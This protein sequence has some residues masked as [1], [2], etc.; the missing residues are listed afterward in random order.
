MLL[1]QGLNLGFGYRCFFFFPPFFCNLSNN[2]MTRG[3]WFQTLDFHSRCSIPQYKLDKSVQ[4]RERVRSSNKILARTI[5][6]QAYIWHNGTICFSIL[7]KAQ[8]TI[9]LLTDHIKK[10][11]SFLIEQYTPSAIM[12]P[13]VRVPLQNQLLI[14]DTFQK[15]GFPLKQQ[16]LLNAI[17]GRILIYSNGN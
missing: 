13:K 4:E 7:Y 3:I 9:Y 14:H 15:L 16:L 1:C 10:Q 8:R 17:Y 12:V 6:R 11:C 5:K 2:K